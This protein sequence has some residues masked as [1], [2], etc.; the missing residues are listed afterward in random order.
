MDFL[1]L[2]KARYSCRK[3]SDRR[4]PRELLDKILEAGIA[5]PTAVN[6]QC[7][8]MWVMTSPEAKAAIREATTCHFGADAFILLGC[9]EEG[10]WVRS[11]DQRSF[12]DVDGAI[13]A[14]HLMLEIQD[15]GLGTTWVG[16]FDAPALKARFPQ[17]EGYDLIALFPIGY[18]AEDA[19]PSERHTQRKSR[20]ELVEEL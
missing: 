18:P 6:T 16:W 5:A 8:K 9:R 14:T 20:E 17:M 15:L 1:E 7:F 11:Y 19:A 3:F 2:S 10:A 4:V 13:A 12:S